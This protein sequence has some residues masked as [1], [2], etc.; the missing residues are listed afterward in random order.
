MRQTD[1]LVGNSGTNSMCLSAAKMKQEDAFCK[2]FIFH[3]SEMTMTNTM[4]L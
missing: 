3:S 2:T 1:G 4:R